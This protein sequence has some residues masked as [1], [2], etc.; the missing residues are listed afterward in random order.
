MLIVM[1]VGDCQGSVENSD[2]QMGGRGWMNYSHRISID[3]SKHGGKTM[4]D[5]EIRRAII[6]WM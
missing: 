5:S 2:E 6:S 1:E 4:L 3:L